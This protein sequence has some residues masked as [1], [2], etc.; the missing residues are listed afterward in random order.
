VGINRNHILAATLTAVDARKRGL[1][2]RFVYLI[3]RLM[4]ALLK[5]LGVFVENHDRLLEQLEDRAHGRL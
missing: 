5:V 4:L 1:R 3:E 2:S